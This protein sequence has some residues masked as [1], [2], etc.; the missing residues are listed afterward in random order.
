VNLLASVSDPKEKPSQVV[1]LKT[2]CWKG[3]GGELNIKRTLKTLKKF[4]HGF[5]YLSEDCNMVGAE[6]VF[7]MITNLDQCKDGIYLVETCNQ[8]TD[9][10]TG[11]LEGYDYKLVPFEAES[12]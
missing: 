10:E 1:R 5:E 2:S 11:F 4:S 8:S 3:N 12:T 6:D 7:E 9:W